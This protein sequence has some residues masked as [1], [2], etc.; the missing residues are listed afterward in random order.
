MSIVGIHLHFHDGELAKFGASLVDG[1]LAAMQRVSSKVT[2]KGGYEKYERRYHQAVK[3]MA[4]M[5]KY[6]TPDQAAEI[7]VSLL[8]CVIHCFFS[9]SNCVTDLLD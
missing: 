8:V 1:V 5:K 3:D 9:L 7:R 4:L 6:L 2:S